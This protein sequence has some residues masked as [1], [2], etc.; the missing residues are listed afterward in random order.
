VSSLLSI[1]CPICGGRFKVHARFAGKRGRCPVAECGGTYRV[2]PAEEPV[3]VGASSPK[4]VRVR[5]V[6]QPGPEIV[7]PRDTI[8]V[9][10]EVVHREPPL[11]AERVR[12]ESRP[13][14]VAVPVESSRP[15]V[16]PLPVPR[17]RETPPTSS[18]PHHAQPAPPRRVRP[19]QS[20]ASNPPASG[21]TDR[22]SRGLQSSPAVEV[23][24]N[25]LT[26]IGRWSRDRRVV[27]AA[28]STAG[29]LVVAGVVTFFLPG[30]TGAA[31]A[32]AGEQPNGRTRAQAI[33]ARDAK[34]TDRFTA[35]VKPFFLKHC[36]ACHDGPEA[37]AG[38]DFEAYSDVASVRADRRKWDDVV[39]MLRI[40]AM[41]PADADPQPTN[42]DR[43]AAL[44]W[45]DEALGVDCSLERDPGRVTIRRLNRTEYDNTIRDL[46]GIDFEPAADFPSD[47]VGEGFDNIA[48]VLSLPPLL[49]EKYVSAAEKVAEAAIDARA[50]EP[51]TVTLEGD[52]LRSREVRRPDDD[53]FFRLS[54]SGEVYGEIEFPHTGRY[55]IRIEAS[56]DQAGDE[57][58][59]CQLLVDGKPVETFDVTDQNKPRF[60]ETTADVRA[61]RV[62]VAGRFVNDFYDPDNKD[63]RRRDRNLHLRTIEVRSETG[64]DPESL[65]ATHRRIVVAR[66]GDGLSVRKAA[67]RVLRPFT[68]R[69][70][71]RPV[72]DEELEGYAK[73]VDLVVENGDSFERG[74]QVAVTGVL[75]SPHFLF[76]IE[77]DARPQDPM[78]TRDLDDFELATRMSY[79][80]WSTMPDDELFRL[81][82]EKRLHRPDV[83]EAQV[84]RMLADPKSRALV[85]NFGGQWLNL[86]LLEGIR[87]DPDVFGKFDDRLKQDMQRETLAFFEWILREDRSVL[88]FVDAKTT[89]VNERLARHYGIEGVEGDEFRQVSLDGL[90]RAG[91]LTQGSILLLT[92]NPDRT[93]LVKRGKWIMENVLGTPPPEAPP[94]VPALEETGK[95]NPEL[96]LREQLRIHRDNPTC[97]SCHEQMD[98]LGFAFENFDAIGRYRSELNGRELDTSGVL[99]SGETFD[100]PLELIAILETEH[101]LFARNLARKMSTYALGRGLEYYDDCAV[102][103]ITANLA[104]DD[105]R[106]SRLVLEIVR[107]EPFL[108]RR[109]DGDRP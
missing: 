55:T 99:P 107:S 27:V 24:R 69:A 47:D 80:I 42:A 43:E 3:E 34:L 100:G 90:P 28:L 67:F 89:F 36:L 46:V 49:L 66:P 92:S 81:A 32:A 74:I 26:T 30:E 38:L 2:P 70:F 45:L 59:K 15:P 44:A 78:T 35:H 64:P 101:E 77:Q 14:P 56:A 93:S 50:H 54:S 103:T 87:P 48:D 6:P 105:H 41:P 12:R 52:R 62:R 85:E 22:S 60:Y 21:T 53:G 71:R 58:A 33:A 68:F 51:F 23:R 97:R 20:A 84:R 31:R 108:K 98:A 29:L 57:D 1:T 94:N 5:P 4:A 25:L 19:P 63:R 7:T 11:P 61:G 39:A 102:R 106:F 76:R 75:V 79:F 65:P 37:E 8:G 86:G 83:L 109:G 9:A 73:L 18:Q 10:P 104:K 91:V 13:Q 40:K 16:A 88:D 82:G 95:L 72:D 96:S 17:R